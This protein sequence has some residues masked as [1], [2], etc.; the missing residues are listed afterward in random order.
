MHQFYQN[1]KMCFFVDFYEKNL[2]DFL[3]FQQDEKREES[4]FF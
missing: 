1:T 4:V 2:K 3:S